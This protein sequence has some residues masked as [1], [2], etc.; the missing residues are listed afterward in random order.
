MES[1]RKKQKIQRRAKRKFWNRKI[2]QPNFKISV[3]ELKNRMKITEERISGF[4][5]RKLEIA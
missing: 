2:Q 5:E 3:D 1:F 4:K